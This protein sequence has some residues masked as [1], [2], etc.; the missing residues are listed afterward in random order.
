MRARFGH[1]LTD[2]GRKRLSNEDAFV[3]DDAVGLYL[4]ADGMGGHSAGEVASQEA[5]ATVHG[6]VRREAELLRE[7]DTLPFPENP[8][9]PPE[10]VRRGMRV[11]ESS[12]QAAT[13][14]VHAMAEHNPDHRGMGTTLSAVLIRG[15]VGISAQVGDS[16]VYR[17]RGEE[18]TQLTEDHTLVAWQVRR[19]LITEEEAEQSRHK[20]MITRAVGSRDYV[21]VDVS[22]FDVESGD[23]FVLCSDGLYGYVGEHELASLSG[24]GPKSSAE[25]LVALANRRG[26]LDNITAVVVQI[27]GL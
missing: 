15:N 11:L 22:L 5:A 18:V 6:M 23:R 21:Q 25:S 12:V 17:I 20:N 2:I 3:V 26:G 13:Y 16:R 4:V 8:G 27:G 24:P 14:L 10:L 19:G 1:G 9:H 7:L